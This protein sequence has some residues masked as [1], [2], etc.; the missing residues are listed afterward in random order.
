[1]KLKPDQQVAIV[2]K[3][4]VVH[5]SQFDP[6]GFIENSAVDKVSGLCSGSPFA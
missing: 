1:M 5:M 6:E 4:G 2:E 3:D